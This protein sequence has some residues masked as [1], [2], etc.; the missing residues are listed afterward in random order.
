MRLL[1]MFLAVSAAL[2]SAATAAPNIYI[3][4]DS[5]APFGRLDDN[6]GCLR[7]CRNEK[8]TCP[9]TMKPK[10]VGDC[11]TCCLKEQGLQ[12][13]FARVSNNE[14]ETLSVETQHCHKQPGEECCNWKNCAWCCNSNCNTPCQ[15]V[16]GVW[17]CSNWGKCG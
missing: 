2:I 3:L 16:G 8:S 10:K 5:H 12:Q 14:Q 1:S 11:W 9:E 13:P 7:A 6:A 4:E 15:L 17:V